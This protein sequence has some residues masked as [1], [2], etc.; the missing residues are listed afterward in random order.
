MSEDDVTKK[1]RRRRS[2]AI[3]FGVA[4]FV[5]IVYLVTILRI[6]ANIGAG[7]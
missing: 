5:T 3:A 2:L 4:G 7:P 6:Q 1:Q